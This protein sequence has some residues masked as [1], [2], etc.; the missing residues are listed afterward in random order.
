MNFSAPTPRFAIGDTIW[1]AATH[2]TTVQLPCPDCLGSRT[3]TVTTPAGSQ[4]ETVCLRCASGYRGSDDLPSLSHQAWEGSARQLLISGIEITG[5]PK[6]AFNSDQ[7]RYQCFPTPGG[8]TVVDE[9]KA[10]ASE[11]EALQAATARAAVK[12]AKIA[13]TPAVTEAKRV[14][15]LTIVDARFDKFKNGLWDAFYAARRLG[16]SIRDVLEQEDVSVDALREAI[17]DALK[18]EA[19]PH[20]K[21]TPIEALA[22]AV[23]ADVTDGVA[24]DRVK[25]ALEGIPAPMASALKAD[26]V[27]EFA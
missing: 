6:G 18:W 4:L 15:A 24:S 9:S 10:Y 14:G 11:A 19:G 21:P 25:Q 26:E 13:A 2:S 12:N 20:T 3:W 7:V 22:R 1:T 8:G 17:E 27:G 16:G 23:E 5:H